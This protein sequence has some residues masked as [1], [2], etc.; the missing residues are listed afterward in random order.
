[1]LCTYGML[2]GHSCSNQVFFESSLFES[3]LSEGGVASKEP[4]HQFHT[5]R[6]P[7]LCVGRSLDYLQAVYVVGLEKNHLYYINILLPS[8]GHAS[9]VRLLVFSTHFELENSWSPSSCLA[10]ALAPCFMATVSGPWTSA[11]PCHQSPALEGQHRGD[12]TH[13]VATT[14]LKAVVQRNAT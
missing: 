11:Q 3:S 2:W 14:R 13:S 5:L 6:I 10:L 8:F 7:S 4:E 12:V 9:N 1:M